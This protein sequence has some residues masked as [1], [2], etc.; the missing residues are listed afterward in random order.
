MG[1]LS[2]AKKLTNKIVECQQG[3]TQIIFVAYFET[4][5]TEIKLLNRI[6]RNSHDTASKTPAFIS[7][8]GPIRL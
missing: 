6:P 7:T 4:N 8:M 5:L 3:E 1:E 2:Y